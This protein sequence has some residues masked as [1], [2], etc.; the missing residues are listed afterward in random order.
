MESFVLVVDDD[1][2]MR[3]VV[4]DVLNDEGF[5]ARG[6]S[7]G[8]EALALLKRGPLPGLVLLDLM[9]PGVTGWQVI[10]QMSAT[11]RTA[12]VPVVVLT[13]LDSSDDLP[14]SHLVL[15]KPIERDLLLDTVRSH[16]TR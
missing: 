7:D 6:A 13:S 2:V 16:A 9:M 11:P 8:E 1:D 12:G 3:S 15:H 5:E 10:D 4:V 14:T